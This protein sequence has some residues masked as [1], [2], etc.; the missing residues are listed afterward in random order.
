MHC[1]RNDT[2]L[3]QLVVIGGERGAEVVVGVVIVIVRVD[4]EVDAL[5]PQRWTCCNCWCKRLAAMPAGKLHG[6]CGQSVA[7]EAPRVVWACLAV[8][9]DPSPREVDAWTKSCLLRQD[10]M[11]VMLLH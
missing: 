9:D 1:N 7:S 11:L 2:Y 3:L 5:L 10:T 8:A 4:A 6:L